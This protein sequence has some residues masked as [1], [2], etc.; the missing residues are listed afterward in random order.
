VSLLAANCVDQEGFRHV[1][2]LAEGHEEDKTGWLG[3]LMQHSLT[4]VVQ[5]AVVATQD[6]FDYYED[7]YGSHI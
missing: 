7:T 2:G 6:E 3:I 1:R 4:S 5:F